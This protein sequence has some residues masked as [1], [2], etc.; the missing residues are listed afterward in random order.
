M[1]IIALLCQI[2]GGIIINDIDNIFFETK[3][4][5]HQIIFFYI[6]QIHQLQYLLI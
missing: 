4:K 3:P 1:K 5:L 2:L 6:F